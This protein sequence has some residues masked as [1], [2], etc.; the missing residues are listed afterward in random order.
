MKFFVAALLISFKAKADLPQCLREIC[1]SQTAEVVSEFELD[2]KLKEQINSDHGQEVFRNVVEKI[3]EVVLSIS[4][5]KIQTQK[6]RESPPLAP[7]M[8]SSPEEKLMKVQG[9]LNVLS[10]VDFPEL[11]QKIE[12]LTEI[13]EILRGERKP[14]LKK[15]QFLNLPLEPGVN[16]FDLSRPRKSYAERFSKADQEQILKL[17]DYLFGQQYY[18]EKIIDYLIFDKSKKPIA[19]FKFYLALKYPKMKISKAIRSELLETYTLFV[20]LQRELGS[21]AMM[22]PAALY[23]AH[24]KVVQVLK[25]GNFTSDHWAGQLVNIRA[26]LLLTSALLNYLKLH[27]ESF[28]KNF[29]SPGEVSPFDVSTIAQALDF[30]KNPNLLAFDPMFTGV[31]LEYIKDKIIYNYFYRPSDAKVVGK[32]RSNIEHVKANLARFTVQKFKY[33]PEKINSLI[34]NLEFELAGSKGDFLNQIY[35]EFSELKNEIDRYSGQMNLSGAVHPLQILYM[36]KVAQRFQ[37]SLVLL[38]TSVEKISVVSDHTETLSGK[39]QLSPYSY[40]SYP[41][42]DFV[43]AHEIAHNL[44]EEMKGKNNP[45]FDRV[46]Q[47]LFKNHPPDDQY[48]TPDGQG[49]MVPQSRVSEDFADWFAIKSGSHKGNPWC[50][51]LQL[52][53]L[54]SSLKNGPFVPHSSDAYRLLWMQKASGA[55]LPSSC[56]VYLESVKERYPMNV[57]D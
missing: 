5:L 46:A 36:A 9:L 28:S 54:P 57:C 7:I 41:F 18:S 10:V 29:E 40:Y 8:L 32:F 42:G 50:G 51:F 39:I 17:A 26:D 37:E 55:M 45:A 14:V 25:G 35:L 48:F 6:L 31:N 47:C 43:A 23:F 44:V 21:A 34:K 27:T 52:D 49:K 1:E 2:H 53:A 20:A 56:T 24:P 4:Q 15:A 16:P 12:S 3:N 11:A 22:M 30:V 13:R 19:N 38:L 33:N